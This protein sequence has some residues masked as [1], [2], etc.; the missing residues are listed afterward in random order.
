MTLVSARLTRAA[1]A[2]SAAAALAL[3]PVIGAG[4]ADA[5][6]VA[7]TSGMGDKGFGVVTLMV[8]NESDAAATTGLTVRFPAVKHLLPEA[9]PGWTSKVTKDADGAVTEIRW[10]ADPGTPGIPVGEFTE[11]NVSGG[12]FTG[13]V[14]LP[15]VQV[16]ANGETVAWDQQAGPGGDEPEK[17]APTINASPADESSA[18]DTLA[19]WLGGLGLLA[20]AIGVGVGVTARRGGRSDG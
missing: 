15:A 7:R 18:A 20:G 9:K 16:Y 10:T 8:P 11:F 6:V 19:R 17:P 4:S 12:P 3:A 2:A 1:V 13:E 5:H 14:V